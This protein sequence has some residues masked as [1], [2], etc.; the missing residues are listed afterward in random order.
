MTVTEWLQWL[1]LR[2]DIM[3]Q[4]LI[5]KTLRQ[6]IEDLKKRIVFLEE[7][8]SVILGKELPEELKNLL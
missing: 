3:S 1:Q 5:E 4:S 6:E 7:Q 8:Q 2:G